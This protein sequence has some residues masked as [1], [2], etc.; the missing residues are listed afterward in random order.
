MTRPQGNLRITRRAILLLPVSASH[1]RQSRGAF[2]GWLVVLITYMATR[3]VFIDA[4]TMLDSW[5]TVGSCA[6]LGKSVHLSS[7]AVIGGVL[8]PVQ[9]NPVIIEDNCFICAV[10]TVL[11]GVIVGENSVLSTGV[12]L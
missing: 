11:E 10:P 4:P 2:I 9:A 7:K 3:G 8:E 12:L 1:R 5:A 6:Q